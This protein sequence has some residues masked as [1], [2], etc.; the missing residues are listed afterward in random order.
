MPMIYDWMRALCCTAAFAASI[1]SLS[2][3]MASASAATAR[4]IDVSVDVALERFVAEVKG[5]KA[6][7]QTSKGVLVF[8]Q[9]LKAGVGFGGEYGE[10]AL[11][12]DTVR[13]PITTTRWPVPSAFSSVPR[14]RP[15]FSY[16]WTKKH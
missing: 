3:W 16:S 5:A 14:P 15:S 10:G 11:R 8:L 2:P 9:V 13:R 4:E 12:L 7:L 6:F 1:S